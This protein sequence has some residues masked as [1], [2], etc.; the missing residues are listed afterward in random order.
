[1]SEEQAVLDALNRMKATMIADKAD[2]KELINARHDH[3]LAEIG[4]V[5]DLM[6]SEFKQ[7]F[8]R[9]DHANGTI[10][11]H[12]KSIEEL[13][14]ADA[15]HL[16]ICPALPKIEGIKQD[17]EEYRIFKKYPKLVMLLIFVF[18]L[19]LGV[20]AYGTYKAITGDKEINTL[21]QEWE[22]QPHAAPQQ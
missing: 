19:F 9:L 12:R 2:L 17:L 20:S 22:S 15:N 1:M 10:D 14:L 5:N 11:E 7:V 6:R 21:K 18:V 16:V 8:Q 3:T 13:R 4:A